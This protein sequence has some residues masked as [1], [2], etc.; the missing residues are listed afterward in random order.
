MYLGLVFG[1]G[2]FPVMWEGC[3]DQ[4]FLNGWMNGNC[5]V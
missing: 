5:V 4:D 3:F 2:I 1:G